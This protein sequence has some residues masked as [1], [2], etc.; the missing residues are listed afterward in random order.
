MIV[1]AASP[2]TPQSN[3]YVLLTVSTVTV[4]LPKA[5]ASALLTGGTSLDASN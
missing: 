2:L 1:L 5:F 4:T 3:L